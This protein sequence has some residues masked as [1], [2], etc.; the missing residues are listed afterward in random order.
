MSGIN[1]AY[2]AGISDDGGHVAANF[3]AYFVLQCGEHGAN[4]I[5]LELACK[6]TA[7][8]YTHHHH[9]LPPPVNPRDVRF[10]RNARTLLFVSV[11][12]RND[13]DHSVVKHRMRDRFIIRY[14]FVRCIQQFSG[15][16]VRIS[17][18]RKHSHHRVQPYYTQ[19]AVTA[20]TAAMLLSHVSDNLPFRYRVQLDELRLAIEYVLCS[21]AHGNNMGTEIGLTDENF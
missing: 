10:K 3:L 18:L 21:N 19:T 17:R 20:M 16:I 1:G 2:A 8:I 4:A 15:H 13:E 7:V 5:V 14:T 12:P 11:K 6:T 9:Y